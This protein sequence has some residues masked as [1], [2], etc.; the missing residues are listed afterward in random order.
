MEVVDTH[1]VMRSKIHYCGPPGITIGDLLRKTSSPLHGRQWDARRVYYTHKGRC[2]LGLLCQYWKLQK[3][4][5]VLV[6]AY[7]CGSEIDP[8]VHYGL[9][10][11]FYRVDHKA[12]IDFEDIMRRIT[13]R[14]KV[15]YVT[16]YFG[17]PQDIKSLSEYC[18]KNKIYLIEDCALSL[19]SNSVQNPIGVL[20][21]AAIYSLPKTLPVPDGGAL[22][23]SQDSLSETPAQ[24]P[25]MGEIFNEF[26]PLVKRMVLRFCDKIGLY[27]YLPNRLIQSRRCS[28]D[29]TTPA[30]LPGIPQSYYYDRNI[31]DMTASPITCY[32]VKHTCPESVVQ[33]RRTNYTILYEAIKDSTLFKPLYK[34]LPE[35]VCPLYLPVLVENRK[36]VCDYLNHKG[37]LA[38]QWWSG[39]HEAFDWAD[40]SGARYLK[41]HVLAIPIHQQLNLKD[42]DYISSFL[43]SA[44]IRTTM[45]VYGRHGNIIRVLYLAGA[46]ILYLLTIGGRLRWKKKVILC[47]HGIYP[48]QKQQFEQQMAKLSQRFPDACITFDDAF[49]NLIDN[50]MPVLDEFRIPAIVF[51]VPGNLGQSPKWNIAAD[52]PDCKEK[53]MTAQQLKSIQN[54]L[55]AIGSHTQTHPDLSK[56]PPEQVRWEL[57]ESK[58][59]LEQLL[60]KSIEDLALP[61]GAYNQNVLRIAKEIGYKRV[62]TL[63]PKLVKENQEVGVISRFSMSP[64]VCPI[65]FYLT[66]AGA[67]SWLYSFRL[68]LKRIRSLF[69]WGRKCLCL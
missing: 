69:S 61:H 5:Q 36:A 46:A 57:T 18:R 53:T 56:L 25:P 17:W 33:Q 1:S 40:F 60:D 2:G 63:E 34:E 15:V 12:T 24:R 51:A 31:Q 44:D 52:H 67:Y 3:G 22:T 14:T 64:D 27:S 37:I 28:T 58:K 21:D 7:N 9:D 29:S 10:V 66:C 4:D 19:F 39:F 11:V 43:K 68:L 41:E 38:I 32:I 65:E 55:I 20:G 35:G 59:K 26:L 8:F 13:R 23:I 45:T 50:A 54:E 16:H 49:E 42:V 30:G 47:Y 48:E 6:P 62:Y